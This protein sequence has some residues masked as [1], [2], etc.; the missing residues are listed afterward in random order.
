MHAVGVLVKIERYRMQHGHFPIVLF[1]PPFLKL[2]IGTYMGTTGD[3]IGLSH[4]IS[5]SQN[6][7]SLLKFT[8]LARNR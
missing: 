6:R 4:P 3:M 8:V 5:F 1:Y 2:Y 7:F